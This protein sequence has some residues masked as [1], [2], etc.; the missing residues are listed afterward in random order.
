MNGDE[1]VGALF[2]GDGRPFFQ[3]NEGVIAARHHHLAAGVIF[4]KLLQLQPHI[5]DNIFL[6]QTGGSDGSRVVAAVPGIDD[7]P[8]DFQAQRARQSA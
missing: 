5:Q 1:Q 8:A 2:I 7:D 6:F 3:G 4:Q